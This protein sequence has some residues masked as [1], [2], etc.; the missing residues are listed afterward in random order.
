MS[1][2]QQI[3]DFIGPVIKPALE[4]SIGAD[5]AQNLVDALGTFI[6]L[7]GE[8]TILFLIVSFIIGVILEYM[9]AEKIQKILGSKGGKGYVSAGLLGALTPFCSCS[10]IPMLTGLLKA[11]AGFGPTITFLFTSPLMNPIIMGLLL[12]TFG[13][14]VTVIYFAIALTVSV[15]GGY[16]LEKLGFERYVRKD[17]IYGETEAGS[18]CDSKPAPKASCCDAKPVVEAPS[19]EKSSS[20][21]DSKPAPAASGCATACG[22]SK[23]KSNDRWGR[24][25]DETWSQFKKIFPILMLGVGIGAFTYGFIPADFIAQYAGPDNPLAIPFAAIIGVPLYI[26]AEAVIP[27]A[28]A[29]AAK[30]MGMGALMALII[31]SA[32]ASL[33]EVILLKSLF[34][35]PMIVAFLAVIFTMAISAGLVMTLI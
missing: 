14:K 4:S 20:C 35:N 13:M 26:R 31:G 23:P 29:L 25:W 24:I 17:V 1:I 15:A 9:P 22:D 3:T 19:S 7:A 30:G 33:T 27:L 8:L 11:R 16:I 5:M 6:F 18:C 28:A 12:A 32:G 10:T 2:Q 34:R 21:C